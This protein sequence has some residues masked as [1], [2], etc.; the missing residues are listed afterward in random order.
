M[1]VFKKIFLTTKSKKI[2]IN[3]LNEILCEYNETIVDIELINAEVMP[4]QLRFIVD[5]LEKR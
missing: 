2:L 1:F 5:D 4:K 3:L